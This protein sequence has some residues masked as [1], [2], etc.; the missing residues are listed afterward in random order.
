MFK[1]HLISNVILLGLIAQKAFGFDP[2]TA[3]TATS[4]AASILGSA[5]DISETMGDFGQ[6]SDFLGITSETLDETAGLSSDLGYEADSKELDEQVSQMEDLN[7]KLK[8]IKWNSQDLKY[9]FDGD[10][11]RAKSLAQKIRQIRK[12]VSISKKLA[13][14]F[15]FKTK[16]SEK[17]ATLQQVKI[18]SMM[19]DELQSMRRLQLIAYLEEKERE[20]RK[21]IYLNKIV[22][23][24]EKRKRSVN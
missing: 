21:D 17:V 19:L 20:A 5:K 14:A 7:Q 3:L 24:E 11:H 4:S 18:N 23:Q 12:V 13:G 1:Y 22:I 8:E 2:F 15:G 16:G 10:I 9:T 6:F